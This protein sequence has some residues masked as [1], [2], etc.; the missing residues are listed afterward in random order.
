VYQTIDIWSLGCVFSVAATWV[1]L[2]YPGVQ[3]YHRLRRKAIERICKSR[4]K[5]E[6]N[7]SGGNLSIGD[8]FHDGIGLSPAV[9]GWHEFLSNTRRTSDTITAAVLALVESKMLLNDPQER[10]NANGLC[11]AL[12]SILQNS[13]EGYRYPPMAPI[14]QEIMHQTD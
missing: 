12:H 1:V 8:Y 7:S 13:V 5:S 14:L 9:K 6:T 4:E 11:A 2:G 3:S 10:I